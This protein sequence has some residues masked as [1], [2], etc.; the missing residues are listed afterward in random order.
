[1]LVARL[2]TLMLGQ[3]PTLLMERTVLIGVD[4]KA[5]IKAPERKQQAGPRGVFR[6]ESVCERRILHKE[7]RLIPLGIVSE[8]GLPI[9]WKVRL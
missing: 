5:A 2:A 8:V 4:D 9:Q 6:N 3:S 7:R 1:M